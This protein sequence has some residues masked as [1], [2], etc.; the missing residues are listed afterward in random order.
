MNIIKEDK[1]IEIFDE[2]DY[3]NLTVDEINGLETKLIELIEK[4]KNIFWETINNKIVELLNLVSAGEKSGLLTDE[5]MWNFINSKLNDG[6]R[7]DRKVR[8]YHNE[9]K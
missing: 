6:K 1:K 8:T 4:N 3:A 5:E 7:Q 9:K 2:L